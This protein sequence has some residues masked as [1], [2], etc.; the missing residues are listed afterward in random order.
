M[1][2]TWTTLDSQ[3]R[4]AIRMGREYR[5][6][7]KSFIEFAK[8]NVGDATEIWCLCKVCKNNRQYDYKT[9]NFHICRWGMLASYKTWIYHGEITTLVDNV[10]ESEHGGDSDYEDPN[11]YQEM[12]EDHYMGTYTNAKAIHSNAIRHFERML[13]ASQRPLYLGCSPNN[14]LLDFVIKMMEQKVEG[15]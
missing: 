4:M 3:D 10:V 11:E 12:M 9:V 8:A 14:T 2:K 1:D 6:R 5:D 15:K 7:V 13:D